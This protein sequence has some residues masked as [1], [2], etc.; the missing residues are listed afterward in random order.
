MTN[1]L[2]PLNPLRAFE[3][4]VRLGSLAAAA[5]EL[6]VVRGAVRRHIAA[7]EQHFGLRLFDRDRNRLV[8]TQAARK[9]A[10]A[11]NSA[12]ADIERAAAELSRSGPRGAFRLGIPSPLA[13]WWLMPRLP[14]LE[15]AGL[16]VEIVTVPVTS[17][18]A[19]RK[20]LD[21]LILGGEYSPS[22]GVAGVRFMDD[23]FGP[24]ASTELAGRLQLAQAP[25]RMSAATQLVA[26]SGSRLWED[27]FRES[28]T[29]AVRF[30]RTMEFQDLVLA[31]SAARAGLGVTIAPR[32]TV[33][34]DLL[35]GSLIAPY[36]FISRPAG[37]TFCYREADGRSPKLKMLE[38]WLVAQG[39]E[40]V[41]SRAG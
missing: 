11:A 4:V 33:E 9:L 14:A 38:A 22:P 3:V 23:Q 40:K 36:G 26:A 13:V 12:F 37:Y 34:Q 5:E 10:S 28:C 19:A 18:L 25:S 1:R 17:T 20:D 8:P 16:D 6:G 21:G 24:V 2:P 7:L 35:A 27:W 39:A 41:P 15:A 31:I 30:A 32:S 29:D